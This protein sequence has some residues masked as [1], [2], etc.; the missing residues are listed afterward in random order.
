MKGS[1]DLTTLTGA[2]FLDY[3]RLCAAVLARAHSQ[4][5]DA[6]VI[7]GYLGRSDQFELAVAK[8]AVQ[9]AD[10]AEKDYNDLKSSVEHSR[11][12]VEYGV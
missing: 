5:P 12:P 6:A 4:S 2:E 3:G 11:L 7:D 9:Y 8:W 1:V 10:Q